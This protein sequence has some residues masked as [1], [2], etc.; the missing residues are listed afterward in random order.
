[1]KKKML[2][3]KHAFTFSYEFFSRYDDRVI[4][5]I[6]HNT[7]KKDLALALKIADTKLQEMFFRN[8]SKKT[9]TIIRED[10][11][12]LC[13]FS[14]K[15]AEDT[16]KKIVSEILLLEDKGEIVVRDYGNKKQ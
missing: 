8:M 12:S 10:M 13:F 2:I 5:V 1:M 9:A 16:Q 14:Q 3:P 11:E 6:I 15:Q 4:W 7:N